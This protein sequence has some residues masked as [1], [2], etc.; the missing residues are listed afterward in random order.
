[1]SRVFQPAE[2]QILARVH[3]DVL[4]DRYEVPQVFANRIPLID[5]VNAEFLFIKHM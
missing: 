1:M 5:K 2:R 3:A 4:L